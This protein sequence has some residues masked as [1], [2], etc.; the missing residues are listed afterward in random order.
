MHP[1]VSWAI[2]FFG[3]RIMSLIH[4]SIS[5]LRLLLVGLCLGASLSSFAQVPPAELKPIE[6]FDGQVQLRIQGDRITVRVVIQNWGINGG[7]KIDELRIPI[8]GFLLVQLR[9]GELATII[10]Q[11]RRERRE[12][13]FWT[14]P[15]GVPLGLETEDDAASIQTIVLGRDQ[16]APARSSQGHQDFPRQYRQYTRGLLARTVFTAEESE[17]PYVVEIWDFLVGPGVKSD[18]VSLPGAAVFEVRSGSGSITINKEPRQV[19]IG[20]TLALDEGRAFD[21]ANNMKDQAIVIRATIIRS[22]QK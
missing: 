6:R 10:N 7:Q 13:E 3:D 4:I 9:G 22:R 1:E 8:K 21:L 5:Q 15:T 20:S 17:S 18:T 12:D 19:R 14:V 2:N 11:E 16:A